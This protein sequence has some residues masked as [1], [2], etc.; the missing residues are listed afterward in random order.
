MFNPPYTMTLCEM[1]PTIYS[2]RILFENI[3]AYCRNILYRTVVEVKDSPA[4]LG[5]RIGFQFI[6]E[7]LQYA[8]K[9]KYNG[10]IDGAEC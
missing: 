5:N 7:V 1:M 8:Q 6:N 10:G 2:N 9:Y 4:F 3:M